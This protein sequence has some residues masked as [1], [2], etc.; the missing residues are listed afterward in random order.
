VRIENTA[1]HSRDYHAENKGKCMQKDSRGNQGQIFFFKTVVMP[2]KKRTKKANK[3][4]G[5]K[6]DKKHTKIGEKE[7]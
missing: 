5:K 3:K 6:E 1:T 7:L 4:T 2:R